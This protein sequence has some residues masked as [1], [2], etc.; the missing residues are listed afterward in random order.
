[1][2]C[3]KIGTFILTKRK[4]KNMTQKQLAKSLGI[5]EQ[6]VSKWERGLGIPDVSLLIDL[7][8][9][10]DVSVQEILTGERNKNTTVN[11]SEKMI[12]NG[13][14]LYTDKE[15]KIT[16]SKILTFLIFIVC[17]TLS[18]GL[19]AYSLI[20]SMIR[21]EII[22]INSIF[23]FTS[24]I[25]FIKM[26][27]N[28]QIKKTICLFL[29]VIYCIV[30]ISTLFYTGIFNVASRIPITY[31]HNFIPFNTLSEKLNWII[32][33]SQTLQN[34]LVDI[35]PNLCLFMPL[36]LFISILCSKKISQKKYIVSLFLIILFKEGIQLVTGYG[37]F[38]VDD[39]LL[40]F[41]GSMMAYVIFNNKQLGLA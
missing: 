39:I 25:I 28:K 31:K 41:I 15:K 5:T 33:G 34:V 30:L 27:S 36:S 4:D 29:L 38:D 32:T 8:K 2:D 3:Q 18:I 7:S 26:I 22:L 24:S 9:I 40:N 37:V 12:S 13:L 10:L 20:A 6:A 14:I 1:M 16:F 23:L 21:T 11:K 17:S 35:L 19:L